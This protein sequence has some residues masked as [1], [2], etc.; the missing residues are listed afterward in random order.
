MKAY[1]SFFLRA[2]NQ[3]PSMA[4][5]L[6]AN[7]SKNFRKEVSSP[8]AGAVVTGVGFAGVGLLGV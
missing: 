7:R 3:A 6:P 8:V 2:L 1:D 4:T 5:P